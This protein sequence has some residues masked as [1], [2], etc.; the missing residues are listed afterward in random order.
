MGNFISND[1]E[2]V[3]TDGSIPEKHEN[4]AVNGISL[5]VTANGHTVDVPAKILIPE[6]VDSTLP[7]IQSIT[8]EAIPVEPKSGPPDAE[9]TPPDPSHTV[10]TE[11]KPEDSDGHSKVQNKEQ[12]TSVFRKMFKTKPAPAPEQTPD[13]TTANTPLPNGLIHGEKENGVINESSPK[14]SEMEVE[15][16]NTEEIGV[17]AETTESTEFVVAESEE[18]PVSSPSAKVLRPARKVSVFSKMFKKQQPP[19]SPPPAAPEPPAPE[20]A[21]PVEEEPK[22][23]LIEDQSDPS[24]P[25]PVQQPESEEQTAETEVEEGDSEPKDPESDRGTQDSPAEENPV[26]NF[27]KTLVTPTKTRKDAQAP[28][29]TKEQ[30][31]P[32]ETQ[33]QATTTT[34][35]AQVSD[36]QAPPKGM[37]VPPPPPPEP[38]RVEAAAKA[39]KPKEEAK[40]KDSPKAKSAK[41][42]LTRLF[43]SKKPDASKASTLEAAAKPAQAPAAQEEKKP[44]A[45]KSLLTFFKPKAADPKATASPAAAAAEAAPAPAPAPVKEETPKAAKSTEATAESKPAAVTPAGE[46]VPPKRLEKRNS[47]TLFFKNLS[48]KRPSTDAGATEAPAASAEKSKR[49]Y[50]TD[51]AKIRK[52]EELK[53]FALERYDIAKKI[54]EK[55]EEQKMTRILVLKEGTQEDQ[56]YKQRKKSVTLKTQEAHSADP[57]RLRSGTVYKDLHDDTEEECDV[58][59][60]QRRRIKG[61]MLMRETQTPLPRI[62]DELLYPASEPE[63]MEAYHKEKHSYK[64]LSRCRLRE[65]TGGTPEEGVEGEDFKDKEA[66]VKINAGYATNMDTGQG[67]VPT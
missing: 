37:P 40:T 12:K 26:M 54:A 61:K 65:D 13:Q 53:N 5:T 32:S 19:A 35:V 4:G 21:A 8:T 55:C 28:D 2:S 31:Q 67:I 9:I 60:T 17:Q 15:P 57:G 41:G 58:E 25:V 52:H 30:P 47:I 6:I 62:N 22:E 29:A 11:E 49:G 48:G 51:E 44:E 24:P 38:P 10:H 63:D 1:N 56:P 33:P 36:P 23:E 46:E 7:E 34:T 43:K 14:E 42:T 3:Q 59:A 39:V 20:P 16:T 66:I 50:V 27:F 45:K 18:K 64:Q